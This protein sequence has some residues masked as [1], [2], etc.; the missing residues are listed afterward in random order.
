MDSFFRLVL[1]NLGWPIVYIEGSQVIISKKSF[2]SFSGDCVFV[3]TNSED[4]GGMQHSAAFH[5][6]IHCLQNYSF[7]GHYYTKGK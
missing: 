2:A 3:L 6:G 7:S 1:I 5:L 4:P